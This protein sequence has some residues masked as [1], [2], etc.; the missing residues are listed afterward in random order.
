M[1]N[2]FLNKN[3]EKINIIQIG[4]YQVDT[5]IKSNEIIKST[6]KFLWLKKFILWTFNLFI[7]FIKWLWSHPKKLITSILTAIGLWLLSLLNIKLPNLPFLPI[8]VQSSKSQDSKKE[9]KKPE[10]KK[11]Q[12][13][14]KPTEQTKTITNIVTQTN[15]VTKTNTVTE[16][17]YV[18]NYVIQPIVVTNTVIKEVPITITNVLV[19]KNNI[20]DTN[21]NNKAGIIT[22]PAFYLTDDFNTLLQNQQQNPIKGK[23]VN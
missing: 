8:P 2:R 5:T 3:G 20:T 6:I 9:D 21:N 14:T 12:S 16:T 11:E 13:N 15:I 18:T 10:E 23:V 1:K 7:R 17:K 22:G 4:Q 19:I